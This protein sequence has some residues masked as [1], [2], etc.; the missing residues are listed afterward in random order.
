M[1]RNENDRNEIR[2]SAVRTGMAMGEVGD[3]LADEDGWS[4]TPK[5][6]RQAQTR[7]PG[8]VAKPWSWPTHRGMKIVWRGRDRE[9]IG[10]GVSKIL[11]RGPSFHP[12]GS[13]QSCHCLC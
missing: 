1:K 3:D 10:H 11:R 12:M 13:Q 6:V 2:S 7:E 5:P 9:T 4:G 8:L